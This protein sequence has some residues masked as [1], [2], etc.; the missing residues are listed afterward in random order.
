MVRISSAMIQTRI[1]VQT[2]F[3]KICLKRYEEMQFAQG[4]HGISGT[5]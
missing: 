2:Q 5:A 1:K 4:G 3:R